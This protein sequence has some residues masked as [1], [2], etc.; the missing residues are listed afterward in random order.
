MI[1]KRKT[2]TDLNKGFKLTKFLKVF[3]NSLKFK[4]KT[5]NYYKYL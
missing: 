4:K 2:S 1:N 3:F 5:L